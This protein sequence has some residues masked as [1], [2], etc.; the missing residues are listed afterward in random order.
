[1]VFLNLLNAIRDSDIAQIDFDLLH[2]RYQP[3]FETSAFYA[4][5]V[6]HNYMADAI[7]R[8]KLSELNSKS[9]VYKASIWGDFKPGM[10]PNEEDLALKAGAQVMFIR[11]DKEESKRFYNG[12]LATI[13]SLDD[14]E[15]KVLPQDEE[16]ELTIARETWENKKYYIDEEN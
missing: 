10:F 12:K 2:T 16:K 1:P 4:H 15:V 5:L 11:N 14:D 9:T 7:N 3:N 8:Q 6:P 13:I